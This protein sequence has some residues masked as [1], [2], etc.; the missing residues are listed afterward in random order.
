MTEGGFTVDDQDSEAA[1]ESDE[2]GVRRSK[3]FSPR[4]GDR[5]TRRLFAEF[6][7]IVMVLVAFA[8]SG[9]TASA[10]DASKVDAGATTY[11]S[12]EAMTDGLDGT[13]TF[14]DLPTYRRW[15][16]AWRQASEM[17]LETG[18]WPY[19]ATDSQAAVTIETV[20]GSLTQSKVPGAKYDLL[21]DR[22]KETIELSWMTPPILVNDDGDTG[23]VTAFSTDLKASVEG[24]SVVLRGGDGEVVWQT[25]PFV[26]WDSSDPATPFDEPVV[27][28]ELRD[29]SIVLRLNATM[30]ATAQWPIYLDPTWTLSA[31][32][33]WGSSTFADAVEDKGD[34]NIKIGWLADNFNDNTNDIWTKESGTWTFASGVMQLQQSTTVRAGS[35]WSDQRFGFKL[36]FTAS[37]TAQAY[38]RFQDSNNHYYL[39]VSESGDSLT[40]K[41]KVAGSL[42]TIATVSGVTITTGTDYVAKVVATGNSFEIWW[43]GVQKW[44]GNDSSPPGSPISGYIK[45]A[46]SSTA[47]AYFDDVRVWNTASGTMTTAVRNAGS[48][49]PLQTKAVGTVDAYNQ[50]HLRIRSSA[51]NTVWGPWTNLKADTASAVFYD[52]TDQDRL[53]YY[54]LRVTLTS[55]VDS[56]PALS[57]LTTTEGSPTTNPTSNTGYERWYPYVGGLAN[58]VNGNLWYSQQDLSVRGRGFTLSLVRSYNSLR[59]SEVGPLG[60][61]WTHGYNMKL[62]VNGDLTVTWNDG[63]GSQHTFTP[64]GSSGGY[65][66]PRGLALR[67]VKNADNSFTLWM[68][69][70]GSQAYTSAGRLSSI[71]DRNGNKVTLAYDGSSR[72]T[73]VADDS[74]R[75]LTVGYD[76]SNRI[77]TVTDPGLNRQISYTY[78]GSSN[79]V[80]VKDALNHYENNTYASGRMSAIIDPVGKRIAFTYDSSS[81]VTEMWLG[82]YQSGSVVWQFRE[83]GIAYTSATTR[84]ITNA[85]GYTTTLSLNSFGNPV[86]MPGPST[87]CSCDSRGNSSSYAFDGEM[88]RIRATDGRGYTWATD[89]DQRSDAVSQTDPG[90][91]TSTIGWRE[92][93]SP[94]QYTLLMINQTTFRG[95]ITTLAY[96]AKGNLIKLTNA[97]GDITQQFYDSLGFL[98]RTRDARGYDT[99]YEYNSSR[100]LT[101]ITSTLNLATQFASDVVGRQTAVTTPLG[102]VTTTTYDAEDRQTNVM[103][104]LGFSTK[105]EF[106]A[107][108]DLTKLTDA[109]GNSTTYSYNVTN[110]RV[111]L[112]TDATSNTTTYAYD[113]RGNLASVKDAKNHLTTYQYDTYDRLTKVTSPM[114]FQTNYTYDAAG[115]S[116]GRKDANGNTTTYVYDKLNRVSKINYPAGSFATYAYDKDGNPISEV[117]FGYTKTTTYDE[118]DRVVSVAMNY[119]SFSKTTQYAYDGN[120]NRITMSDADQSSVFT[121]RPNGNGGT[122][123]WSK[124]GTGGANWDRVD[125]VTSDGD[126]TYVYTSTNGVVDLY[127]LTDLPQSGQINFVT[128][129][130]VGRAV[131]NAGCNPNCEGEL[132]LRVNGY[133]SPGSGFATSYATVSYTWPTNPGTGLPW[134]VADVNAL[135]AGVENVFVTATVRVTQVYVT[136]TMPRGTTYMY[137]AGN[138]P[139][140]IMDPDYRNTT[141]AYDKD[142]RRTST[143]YSNTVWTNESYDK[144]NRMMTLYSNESGNQVIESFVYTYDKNGNR[145]TTKDGSAT[146]TYTYDKLNRLVKEVTPG[147]FTTTYV[148]DAVGNR[149]GKTAGNVSTSYFFDNDDRLTSQTYNTFTLTYQYDSNGNLVKEWDEFASLTQYA[150]DAENR[151]TKITPPQGS[152]TTYTYTAS[153]QRISAGSSSTTYYGYDFYGSGGYDDVTAEY[154]TAGARQARYTRGSGI[155][156]PL[157]VLRGSS[158]YSYQ[159]DAEGSVTRLTNSTQASVNTY[160]YDAWGRPTT[161]S[162]TVPNPFRFTGREK[163]SGTALYYYRARTYDPDTGRFTGKDRVGMADETN[164]YA[165]SGNNPLNWIDPSGQFRVNFRD[166]YVEYPT[167]PG[168]PPYYACQSILWWRWCPPVTNYPA[169][170]FHLSAAAMVNLNGALDSLGDAVALYSDFLGAVVSWAIS[171]KAPLWY[172]H[173]TDPSSGG[174]FDWYVPIDPGNQLLIFLGIPFYSAT[175]H[176]WWWSWFIVRSR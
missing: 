75:S 25:A 101:K 32:A 30:L 130:A 11:A 141:F 33:G 14:R 37:G 82:L 29:G 71:G 5:R 79:L 43:Q 28:I 142:S 121:L 126:T 8:G 131:A 175:P 60:N 35:S 67:L 93:N 107:R 123:Q 83:Y 120:G 44:S 76:A 129:T 41:K 10:A 70:G 80:A 161:E 51:D 106:N 169:I 167:Y 139:T 50:T 94:L 140:Q 117:G 137:D 103:N 104:P 160:R 105:Q 65:A 24:P 61:G 176:Y 12:G 172:Y 162:E 4:H 114:G 15:D 149:V 36:R 152:A 146:T 150:Y 66:P 170:H 95:F 124:S 45:F 1:G 42:S 136:V 135:Q 173:Q 6:A 118:L 168:F 88:N 52:E 127:T 69:D 38:F 113:L 147:G 23:V 62:V 157:G 7:V 78:D 128:V 58:A 39:D 116:I 102:S 40:L 155:D 53:Q 55:G 97:K 48:S 100:Y 19:L 145:L 3:D 13:S 138:R 22:I 72:L 110:G 54:Q 96:D 21:P 163:D 20:D 31:A 112:I 57:E 166:S 164:L 64:K 148:Y 9:R 153:G 85:R 133:A 119:G 115:N 144:A 165:Y 108:G 91:N 132:K 98:N 74:G 59:S 109:N 77:S 143:R 18:N 92:I 56:S 90:G 99:W 34:H 159:T 86:S 63:D 174:S 17:D 2:P 111:Q 73:S 158:Y 26:A 171:I 68:P 87:G 89:Y 47:Q 81:R 154:D 156:E 27:G 16:G 151:L 84:T 49:R 134:T 46:T 125:E 122:I